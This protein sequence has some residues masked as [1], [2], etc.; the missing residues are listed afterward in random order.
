M[1]E[2]IIAPQI[3]IADVGAF[4]GVDPGW[5]IIGDC[6]HVYGFEPNKEE[7]KRLIDNGCDFV[8]SVSFVDKAI[9]ASSG[10]QTLFLSRSA[11]CA[12]LRKPLDSQFSR[13]SK[14]GSQ[15]NRR[16]S[17]IR[18]VSVETINLQE[19][20]Q[21][22]GVVFDF[23]KLDTQGTEF[24]ILESCEAAFYD[25]LIGLEVEVEFIPLYEDQKLF[26]EIELFLRNKGFS[27]V[28]LRRNHWKLNNGTDSTLRSGGMLTYGDALFFKTEL[29]SGY[30][31]TESITKLAL[32]A[33]RYDL[34][35]LI[36]FLI[37]KIDLDLRE[38]DTFVAR[39]DQRSKTHQY[40]SHS[41]RENPHEVHADQRFGF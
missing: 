16:A 7:C 37:Q 28:G 36:E 33:L 32:L 18:G 38:F 20:G 24:D 13:F 3:N 26:S 1:S 9:A 15:R 14:I 19:F 4:G 12:S 2:G 8:R 22:N 25:N 31:R 29:V 34:W 21:R 5:A 10:I 39:L 23:I 40:P 17:N 41:S 35:D 11:T 27:L 6:L 30:G